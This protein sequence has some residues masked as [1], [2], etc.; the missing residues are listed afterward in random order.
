MSRESSWLIPDVAVRLALCEYQ[1]Y[2]HYEIQDDIDKNEPPSALEPN[3]DEGEDRT[4]V[5]QDGQF[6]EEMCAVVS[7]EEG[8]QHLCPVLLA[9][10]VPL[11]YLEY[12]RVH[13]D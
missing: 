9:L 5:Q 13:Y 2:R 4:V 3:D 6:Y 7:N 11:I 8:K 10:C 1:N 12:G